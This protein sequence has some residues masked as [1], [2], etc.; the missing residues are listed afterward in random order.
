ECPAREA[1]ALWV[2]EAWGQSRG[3]RAAGETVPSE[4]QAEHGTGGRADFVRPGIPGIRADAGVR[5]LAEEARDRGEQ[6]D[7]AAVDDG[8]QAVGGQ[9]RE[10]PAGAYVAAAAEPVW[11]A[12]AVGHQRTRLAGGTRGE[13]VPDRDD[14]RCHQPVIRT[15]RAAR[16]DRREHETGVELCG[17]IRSAAGVL[18]GQSES[19]SDGREAPAR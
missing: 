11:G 3:P 7:G 16:F 6:G 12:G 5:I 15:V 18:Y 17:E 1:A 10:G 4:D 9:K 19:V 13:V 2:E 14:R 8:G